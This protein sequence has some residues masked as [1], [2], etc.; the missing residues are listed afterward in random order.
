EDAALGVRRVVA[1]VDAQDVASRAVQPGEHD[2][3]VP[4]PQPVLSPPARTPRGPAATPG[5]RTIHAS[6][7]PSKP[8]LGATAGSVS[9]DDTTPIGTRLIAAPGSVTRRS[10]ASRPAGRRRSPSAPPTPPGARA[11]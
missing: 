8:C 1:G 7:A 2:D 9:G 3:V 10:P 4:R 6:G 11:P 5:S